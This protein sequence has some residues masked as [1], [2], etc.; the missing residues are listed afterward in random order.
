MLNKPSLDKKELADYHP[1]SNLLFLVKVT[2]QA[3]AKQ[4]Q[5]FLNETS[6]L[7]SFILD[8]RPGFK[9]KIALDALI[10]NFYLHLDKGMQPQLIF[11][12]FSAIDLRVRGPA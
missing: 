8:Q 5:A 7:D 6:T 9:S 1:V 2:V 10:D 11:L 3:V 4:L 12:A